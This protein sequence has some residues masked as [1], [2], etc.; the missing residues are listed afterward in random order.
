MRFRIR[1]TDYE[2]NRDNITEAVKGVEP[3]PTDG[4][5][6]F[7]VEINGQNYPIKQPIHR[8]TKLLEDELP[9]IAFTAQDA[10]RILAKLGYRIDNLQENAARE[11]VSD[12]SAEDTLK[13]VIT[14][15]NDEDGFVVASCPALPG[16]HSQGRTREAAI[17]NIKEAIRGYIISMRR[18]GEAVPV[19]LEVAQVEVKV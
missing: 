1:G 14:L 6:R 8:V 17:T 7:C 16:C 9:Y 18:H 5:H 12:V 4:R 19:V 2:I 11:P 10:Y 15:E 13:F 3:N